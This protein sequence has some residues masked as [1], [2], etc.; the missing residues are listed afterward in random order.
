MAAQAP[1]TPESSKPDGYGGDYGP[2]PG[3]EYSDRDRYDG[4]VTF[5]DQHI[6]K[7]LDFI[8]TKPWA[9]RTVIIV[10]S[11]HLVLQAL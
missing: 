5:T 2:P 10:T 4:E 3:A 1:G 11:D 7:L 8:A 6:G 9:A